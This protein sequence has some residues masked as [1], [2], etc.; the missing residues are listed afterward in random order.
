MMFCS[1]HE[2]CS[3]VSVSSLAFWLTVLIFAIDFS[4]AMMVF[5]HF[6]E[7]PILAI[8]GERDKILPPECSKTLVQRACNARLQL[9]PEDTHRI[10]SAF[11]HVLEFICSQSSKHAEGKRCYGLAD[12]V[13]HPAL[14]QIRPVSRFA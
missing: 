5:L 11:P 14:H 7:V 4:R 2:G 3:S 10:E 9:L 6:L 1:T 12:K 8:H 13:H